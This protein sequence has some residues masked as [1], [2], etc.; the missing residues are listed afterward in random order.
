MLRL[1]LHADDAVV[2]VELDDPVE[3]REAGSA[4][5]MHGDRAALP[6]AAARNAR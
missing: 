3:R 5:P 4:E 2:V 1:L 6:A